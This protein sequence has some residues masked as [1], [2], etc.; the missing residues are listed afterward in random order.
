MA[1]Q[2]VEE[3]ERNSECMRE[4]EARKRER[5]HGNNE[6]KREGEMSERKKILKK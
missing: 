5:G 1:E 3:K 6:K 4:T 2:L